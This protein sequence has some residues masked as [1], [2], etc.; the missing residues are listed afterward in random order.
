MKRTFP[1]RVVLTVTTGRLL[2]KARGKKDNGISDLY[3]ILEHMTEDAPWTH[4]LPRFARECAPFLLQSF[5]ELAKADLKLLDEMRAD[6]ENGIELW[7]KK[8]ETEFGMSGT[9]EI[10]QLPKEEHK[11][12]NP[13]TELM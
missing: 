8:C 7:L 13:F 3:E 11:H 12:V 9:Y 10:D 4:S 2:T 1:L 6:A 5:P